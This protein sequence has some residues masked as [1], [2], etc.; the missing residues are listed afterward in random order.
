MPNCC[1]HRCHGHGQGQEWS[2]PQLQSLSGTVDRVLGHRGWLWSNEN[3]C[4]RGT[5]LLNGEKRKQGTYQVVWHVATRMGV[6]SSTVKR[7][8]GKGAGESIDGCYGQEEC[9]QAHT[10]YLHEDDVGHKVFGA[11]TRSSA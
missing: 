4:A 1:Q 8:I 2:S 7:M 5:H 3:K 10:G 11:Q 9:L 6:A